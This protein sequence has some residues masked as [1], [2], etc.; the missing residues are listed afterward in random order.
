MGQKK[1]IKIYNLKKKR[2][3]ENL[4]LEWKIVL[5]ERKRIKSL[6]FRKEIAVPSGQDHTE[7]CLKHEGK[8]KG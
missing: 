8:K 5:K 7:L 3:Q 6:L 4:I 1:E 2:R